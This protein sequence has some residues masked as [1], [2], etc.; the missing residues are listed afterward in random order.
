[1]S[2]ERTLQPGPWLKTPG[3]RA[4]AWLIGVTLF[5]WFLDWLTG[6]LVDVLVAPVPGLDP[7]PAVQ[8]PVRLGL[9][10]GPRP[11]AAARR[12][13]AP[14]GGPDGRAGEHLRDRRAERRGRAAGPRRG[15]AADLGPVSWFLYTILWRWPL[16]VGDAVLTMFWRGMTRVFG[17]NGGPSIDSFDPAELE[18]IEAPDDRPPPGIASS[19]P[20]RPEAS[21]LPWWDARR[22]APEAPRRRSR[23]SSTASSATCA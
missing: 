4:G 14:G 19:R 11:S 6:D 15:R 8:R 22:R 9:G 18:Q 2:D 23:S 3:W 20:F 1:M 21:H 16:M 5:L 12:H 17:F 7:G 10:E 13:R